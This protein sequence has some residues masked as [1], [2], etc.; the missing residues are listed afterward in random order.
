VTA[1]SVGLSWG[2]STDNVGVAGYTVYRNG[3]PLGTTGSSATTY[4]DTT[5]APSTSYSYTVDAF[6]AAGNHS[7][8]SSPLPVTTPAGPPPSAKWVQGGTLGTG[9]KV[10]SATF[11]LAKPVGAGDLLVGWAGQYD[12][13]GQV[14]VSD[15]VN[16]VWTRATASTK[17]SNGAGDIALY[18]VQNAAA[19]PTGL[20]IT[21]SATNATYLEAALADYSGVAKT[22]AL[23]QTL[24]GT[25][26]STAAD[27]GP[28]GTVAAGELVV[29]GIITGGSPSAVT[30][31]I[32]QGQTFTIRSQSS[33]GSEVLEDVPVSAAGS[34]AARATFAVPTDW[35]AVVATFRAG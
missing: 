7:A 18:Y 1:T 24:V 32:S 33:S 35:Y 10:A 22:G 34:Q 11:Q 6:D 16:G 15:N 30:P 14:Q 23:D 8:Q 25:G 5:E 17:F 28:S 26:N 13:A 27:S 21:V 31:G 12:S 29:G 19:A 9:S 4:S 20:T 3:S 2:A